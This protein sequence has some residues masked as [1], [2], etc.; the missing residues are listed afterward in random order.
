[1]FFLLLLIA[2]GCHRLGIISVALSSGHGSPR[3]RSPA[4]S[5]LR[6]SICMAVLLRAAA[7]RLSG[8]T[9]LS[10]RPVHFG[11]FVFVCLFSEAMVEDGPWGKTKVW[12]MRTPAVLQQER[13][14][15]HLVHHIARSRQLLNS[16]LQLCSAFHLL[17]ALSL[18]YTISSRME[19]LP[20]S[21]L[22]TTK[23]KRQWWNLTS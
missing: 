8:H 19:S 4:H 11:L 10:S 18:V 1:M 12:S 13:A 14:P 17:E 23:N 5:R 9:L 22:S 15:G 7:S 6:A 16:I 21:L 2:R 20:F 3:L